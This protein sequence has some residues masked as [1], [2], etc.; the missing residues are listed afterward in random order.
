LGIASVLRAGQAEETEMTKLKALYKPLCRAPIF[1][2][3][4]YL[5]RSAIEYYENR[6]YDMRTNGELGLL[7]RLYRF[8]PQVVFDVGANVGEW[9]RMALGSF[10]Q[11][12][13]FAFEPVPAIFAQ[14]QKNLADARQ[15][16]PLQKGLSNR[17]EHVQFRFYP[18]HLGQSSRYAFEVNEPARLIDV[19]LACGDEFCGEHGIERIDLLKLDVEGA[20]LDVLRGFERML[21]QHRVDVIQFEYGRVNVRSR[22]LLCDFYD[23]LLE[24][25]YRVGKLYPREVEFRPYDTRHE[26]FIGPNF[27]AVSERR[28]D[29]VEAIGVV[30]AKA[31]KF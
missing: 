13:I 2:A 12:R 22:A 15:I 27:V 7:R 19:P 8:N 25:G 18:G 24:R 23:F 10:P 3:L 6:N 30:V 20:E 9:S 1:K 11:A 28:P 4:A 5:G 21:G 31:P 29:I 26:N 16:V 17:A 14:L